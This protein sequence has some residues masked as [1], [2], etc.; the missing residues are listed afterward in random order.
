MLLSLTWLKEFTPYEGTVEELAHRLTMVGLE[1]EEIQKPFAYLS[2]LVVGHVVE[3]KAHPDADKLSLCQVDIGTGELLPIVCGAPNVASGQKVAVAPVGTVMPNEMLIKKAKIRGQVSKGMICSEIEL[4]LG[5]DSSGIMV[6]DEGLKPGTGL[7][8]ALNL[9]E[10][11][12]DIG[13]TPNRSDC[14]SVLGLARETAAIFDLP[15]TI[16]WLNLQENHSLNCNSMVRVVIDDSYGCPLY[17]ARII[18]E[19]EVKPSPA[20]VRYRLMAVGVR[21]INNIVDVTNYILMELGQPLHSFDND[22]MKGELVRVDRATDGMKFTTLDGQ[23]RTLAKDDLLI[24]DAE[25]PVALAGVMGGAETEIHKDSRN[26]LLECAV[27]DPLSIRKTARRLGLSSEASFR[28]ERG[29]DHPGSRFAIDR[30]AELISSM[31]GGTVAGGVS[32]AEPRPFQSVSVNFRPSKVGSLL[33]IDVDADYC[34]KTLSG[35][36]CVLSDGDNEFKVT[37]PSY[38]PDLEREVDLIEEVGRIYG[39]DRI[40]E[41]LPR[42]KKSLGQQPLDLSFDFIVR[43]KDW[44]R[45]LG[46]NEVVNYSF[47]GRSDLDAIGGEETYRVDVFNPLSEDQNV[48]RT[49]LLPGL[50][51]S[52]R[53]NLGHDNNRLKVFE[54]A[55]AFFSHNQSETGVKEINRLAVLLYGARHSG[56]WP[57]IED[58]FDYADI[59]G[60]LENLTKVFVRLPVNFIQE[61]NHS[62]LS[63]AVR[64]I[65]NDVELGFLGRVKPDIARIYKARKDIWFADIDLDELQKIFLDQEISFVSLPRFPVVRRDMTIIAPMDIK[66]DQIMDVVLGSGANILEEATLTDVYYPENS[67]EKNMTYRMTYRHPDKTLKDKEVE[68]VHQKIA[69]D[70]TSKLPLRFA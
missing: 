48:L 54:V 1:V 43:I 2:G 25:R 42:I 58:D 16:P 66:H 53:H 62:Y 46:L 38:R 7:I 41:H 61:F 34:R 13:I 22:L 57:H 3:K 49:D 24:W 50:L 47:V 21:P 44:A 12:L 30:A 36:G 56:Q 51:Q 26:V 60:L 39:L 33:A 40:P 14:L 37:A 52:L 68:K 69:Q 10:Y 65:C 5:S 9:E 31:S 15:L 59:K 20:A 35:L 8:Q 64:F 28:F 67:A 45:G 18:S 17:Q 23:Q 11:V 4:E 29:V 27:F 55:R 63:P 6:L 70:L 32:Q 19:C